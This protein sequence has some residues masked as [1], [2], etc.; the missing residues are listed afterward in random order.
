MKLLVL[1]MTGVRTPVQGRDRKPDAIRIAGD[2]HVER[3][4][5]DPAEPAIGIERAPVTSDPRFAAPQAEGRGRDASKARKQ[6]AVDPTAHRTM[7]VINF[8]RR[9]VDRVAQRA[10]LA[11]AGNGHGLSAHGTFP[12]FAWAVNQDSSPASRMSAKGH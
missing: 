2:R 11:A 6:R 7:A 10:A 9:L 4:A 12:L 5:A 8:H 1:R 3:A